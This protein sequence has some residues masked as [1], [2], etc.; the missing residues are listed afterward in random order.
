MQAQ[1]ALSRA[2]ALVCVISTVLLALPSFCSAQDYRRTWNSASGKFSVEAS[3]VSSTDDVVYLK[4]NTDNPI[5]VQL[6]ELSEIDQKFVKGVE[7][8]E[9]DRAQYDLVMPHEGRYVESPMA[10]VE[11]VE[12]ISKQMPDSPYA[13]MMT[14]L[15]YASEMG[16]YEKADRY[17]KR[18]K[19]T[20]RDDQRILGDGFHAQTERS[21]NNNL[22]ISA[23]KARKGNTA[24]K[25]LASGTSDSLIPFSIYHNAT[26]LMQA[27]SGRGS[28]INLNG[29][30]RKKLVGILARK[31]P[32][33]PGGKVPGRF[34]YSLKWNEPMSL[35]ELDRFLQGG[36]IALGSAAA[37]GNHLGGAVFSS[38]KQLTDRGYLEYCSGSGF[39]IT[40]E[41]MLTNRHVVQSSDNSLSYTITQYQ[42][43][44]QPRLVGGSIVKWSAIQ[45]EDL[46]LI[47]LD[48]PMDADPLP[49]NPEDLVDKQPLTIL[50]FP[51][52]DERGE[53]L[54]AANG[55]FVR[56]NTK[57][58]WFY[59]TNQLAAGNSGGPTVD[60]NGNVVG[61][62]FA[63]RDFR[64][65]NLVGSH[66][67]EIRHR[68]EGI[69]VSNKAIKE[70]LKIAAPDLVFPAIREQPYSSGQELVES[71]RGSVM[72]IKS[73][74][75]PTSAIKQGTASRYRSE[76]TQLKL[77]RLATLREKR[78]YPDLQCMR[79]SG[80][81]YLDC[82]NRRCRDG[83]VSRQEVQ[84][85]G[86]D[87]LF[88]TPR[89]QPRI[90]YDKC[91]VCRGKG[92][93]VCP[94][95]DRGRLSL[96]DES[97]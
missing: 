94:D 11:I 15:A 43:D 8:I 70:F 1:R 33:S 92:G 16:D 20:I 77:E 22:A 49:L 85:A 63:K 23:L 61:I 14:G 46:A 96:L 71:V 27:T 72:L 31:V 64:K 60:M 17:F 97:R 59:S 81:G 36:G 45:E 2:S 69:S 73:W 93:A 7:I 6:E 39:L 30:N 62:A 79:C 86:V 9:R 91:Q 90:V 3:L 34:L 41:L 55:Q 56:Y 12:E 80:K 54:A 66:W 37:K 65:Y 50:G 40:P 78:L 82:P 75:P 18:A 48:K 87:P 21:I 13:S 35:A 57:W 88:G 5:E 44:G 19:Q 68:R 32:D 67:L 52:I 76:V 51:E 89:Y 95:C 10:V 25:H 58:P 42:E 26:L 84:K 24:V 38:E 53:H 74:I 83:S 28:Y 29:D 4:T 47:K